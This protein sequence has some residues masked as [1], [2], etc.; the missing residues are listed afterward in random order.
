MNLPTPILSFLDRNFAQFLPEGVAYASIDTAYGR[1]VA[2]FSG[3]AL[4]GFGFM[5]SAYKRESDIANVAKSLVPFCKKDLVPLNCDDT[6]KKFMQSPLPVWLYGTDFQ[7]DVW[8][9]LMNIPFG[10]TRT[11]QD[12]ATALGQPTSVR[13]VAKAIGSNPVSFFIPCHRVIG[14]TGALTGY[15]WGIDVKK[16]LL[17]FEHQAA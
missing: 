1:A 14:A 7:L 11:Y 12:I 5:D 6:L 9:A 2:V 15:R 13:A 10:E 8:E 17:D 16:N 3:H 4:I